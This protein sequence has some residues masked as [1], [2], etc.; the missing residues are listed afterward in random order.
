MDDIRLATNTRDEAYARAICTGNEQDWL[1]FKT[2]RNAVVKIIR[3]KKK[4]YYENMID[5][6]KN[7]PV[8]MW[9]TLK[10]VIR[11][12]ATGSKETNNVDFEIL[13]NVEV[14]TLANKFNRFYIQSI[15]D[16][17]ESI[18]KNNSKSTKT[19]Y[20]IESRGIIENF[21]LVNLQK[22]EQIVM[23]LPRKKGT[24]EGISSDI[25][26]MSFRVIK[27]KLLKVINVLLIKGTCPERWKTSTIIPIP[28]IEK[29]KKASEYRP[30]NILPIYEKVLELVVKEQIDEY[31]YSND[32]IS[33]HQSGFRKYHSCETAIQSVI[34][35]WKLIISEGKMVGVIFLDLKRAFETVD[36]IRL[37]EKLDQY[38]MRG[39][40]LEWFRTYLSN[41]TQQ[42]KFNNQW[43]E[44]IKTEYGVP[45]GSV[46]GPLLFTIYINDIVEYCPEECSI[47]MFADDT[48][49]YVS[50]EGSEELERKMNRVFNIVKE[51]MSVNKLRM[52]ASKTKYM[53]V[54]SVR[55]EL[56]GN[57]MLKCN[58]GIELERVE[59]MKYLGVIIDDKLQFKDH[60]DYMLKKIGKKTSFL[61]RIGNFVSAYTRCIIYKS[62]IAPH[63][64]YCA[65]LLLGM[66][67]TQLNKLQI[68][69]NR[70]MRV[71]LQCNRF[72]K[73]E[74]MLQALQFMS[75]RQRLCY[76]VGVFIFKIVN[77]MASVA[78]SNKIEIIGREC[79]RQTRQAGNIVITFRRTRSAQKSL[80]YEGIKMYN[81]LPTEIKQC[82]G[83]ILFKRA[84]KEYVVSNV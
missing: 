24:D 68:A 81:S 45:Q 55:K 15:N 7:D 41:R 30:I 19:I 14:C 1:Q 35:D 67:E 44:C 71:I 46:L 48:L 40:V 5:D 50:G 20:I 34:D 66:G 64:E 38:G 78:L 3:T 8:L 84:L 39:M 23:A 37:L 51:W 11:G 80:F 63:F 57:I 43:S 83:I 77:N 18:G 36:R 54:R 79:D 58:D 27:D 13:E 42:V 6:N 9:K 69:Q 10:E 26:K 61:N 65:T 53:I 31:L 73:V 49:V 52:N 75:I 60:C 33:E 16:I 72:T 62:I 25:L 56:R 32:I 74:H 82:E 29:P 28:K 2:E 22:L 17:I 59:K 76:N 21:E 70:A 4:E 12:E 47:K